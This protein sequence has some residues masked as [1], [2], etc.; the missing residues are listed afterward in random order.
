MGSVTNEIQ[1]LG[2]EHDWSGETRAVARILAENIDTLYDEHQLLMDVLRKIESQME[3]AIDIIAA[4][5]PVPPRPRMF[6]PID[7]EAGDI[8]RGDW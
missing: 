7:F 5:R 6:F 2:R 1:K 8:E 4:R 3:Q